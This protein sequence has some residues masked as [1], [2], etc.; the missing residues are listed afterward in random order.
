MCALESRLHLK[1]ADKDDSR[2][3][4]A[5]VYQT[6][7]IPRVERKSRCQSVVVGHRVRCRRAL[8]L[9]ELIV[10]ITLL[11]VFASAVMM[12]LGASVFADTGARIEARLMSNALLRSQRAA[13]QTGDTHGL[14]FHGPHSSVTGWSIFQRR[15][16]GTRVTIEPTH[17]FASEVDVSTNHAEVEFDFEG[18]GTTTFHAKLTGPNRAYEVHV[19]PLTRMIRTREI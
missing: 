16:D 1:W 10:V 7:G 9:I 2:P 19:E 4:I 11:G 8:T 3:C 17:H 15:P 12:R 6:N 14:I 13:I 5:A 18:N